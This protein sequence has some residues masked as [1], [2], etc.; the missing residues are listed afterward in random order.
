MKTIKSK[1][2]YC[3]ECNVRP[4]YDCRD[5]YMRL[6]LTTLHEPRVA[7]SLIDAFNNGVNCTYIRNVN[8]RALEYFHWPN[9]DIKELYFYSPF[10][11]IL[12]E[13]DP[14]KIAIYDWEKYFDQYLFEIYR[15]PLFDDDEYKEAEIYF[16]KQSISEKLRGER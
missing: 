13:S 1:K 15:G 3:P 11:R 14:I 10:N 9:Q 4:G 5:F 12:H 7:F 8:W 2:A 6:P 16:S